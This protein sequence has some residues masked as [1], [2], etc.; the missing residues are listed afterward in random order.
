MDV[1]GIESGSIEWTQA[2]DILKQVQTVTVIDVQAG[3]GRLTEH[4]TLYL[5]PDERGLELLRKDVADLDEPKNV[6]C[7]II[8]SISLSRINDQISHLDD[9]VDDELYVSSINT[10]PLDITI[11]FTHISDYLS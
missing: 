3:I 10:Q 8:D 4:Y 2:D 7:E 1:S 6:Q 5:L 11:P 9:A